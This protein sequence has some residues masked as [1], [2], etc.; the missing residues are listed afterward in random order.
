MVVAVVVVV[1][2]AVVVELAAAAAAA[3]AGGGG[4]VVTA[5]VVAVARAGPGA[6]IDCMTILPLLR[7]LVLL[8]L[9]FSNAGGERDGLEHF[10]MAAM[11]ME[12]TPVVP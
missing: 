2:V 8:P 4:V 5:A 6:V 1:V 7:L 9:I 10:A 12:P 11:V 3:A